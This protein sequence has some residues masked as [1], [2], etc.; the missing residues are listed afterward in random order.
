MTFPLYLFLFVYLAFLAICLIF[1]LVA[2]YHMF[3]YGFKTFTTFIITFFYIAVL[4]LIISVSYNAISQINWNF[5]V[6]L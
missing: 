5:Y 2:V 1:S 6:S 3:R 4:I